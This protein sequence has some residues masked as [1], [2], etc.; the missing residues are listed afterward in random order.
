MDQG[1]KALALEFLPP[2]GTRLLGG[3][4]VLRVTR[5]MGGAFGLLQG[6]P[7]LFATLGAVVVVFLLRMAGRVRG[8]LA[9]AGIAL[10]LGGALGNLADR[11]FRGPGLFNGAVVD[12]VDLRFWPVFNLADVAILAGVALL[13]WAAAWGE[14]GEGG[15]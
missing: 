7:L 6:F 10:V 11:L 5:N 4:V 1:S 9:L 8:G 14:R 15:E 13:S 3:L 12:F 2:E